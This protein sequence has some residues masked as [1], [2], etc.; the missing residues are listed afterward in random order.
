MLTWIEILLLLYQEVSD[1]LDS[2][3][4]QL[5]DLQSCLSEASAVPTADLE[6]QRREVGKLKATLQQ[7]RTATQV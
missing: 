1:R 3:A 7:L 4:R 5:D 2:S 6:R